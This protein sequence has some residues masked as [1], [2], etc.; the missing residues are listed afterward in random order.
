MAIKTERVQYGED[1]GYLAWP[2]R[3]AAPL[4]AVLVIQE[5][6]GVDDHIEDVARRFA[7][8]GY[9]ALAPDLYAHG[10]GRPAPFSRE[11][12][13]AFQAFMNSLPPQAWGDPRAREAALANLPEKERAEVGE[14]YGLLFG[15]GLQPQRWIEPLLAGSRFA[16]EQCALTRGRKVGSVGFCMGGGLS[17]FLACSDPGLSAAVVFYGSAPPAEKIAQIRCP[18]LGLYGGKDA[19]VN[20]GIPGFEQ[21]MKA[22]GKR[23]EHHVYEG[24]QHAFFNDGRPSYDADAARD[25]FVRTLEFFRSA[26]V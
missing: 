14:T 13:A 5:A 7:G 20:A 22:A 18:V 1:G 26:L 21:A 15:A 12:M 3:A 24:A 9:A 17:A 10:G 19:R 4:P 2:E 11:R 25:A 8:A 6:W 16:R 23:F